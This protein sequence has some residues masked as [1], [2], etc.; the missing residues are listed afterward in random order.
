LRYAEEHENVYINKL[1]MKGSFFIAE[2]NKH[3]YSIAFS[4]L[5]HQ[6]R[7]EGFSFLR[8]ENWELLCGPRNRSST[9]IIATAGRHTKFTGRLL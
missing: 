5:S 3:I 2:L 9:H 6:K 8:V 4:S 7:E 1:I